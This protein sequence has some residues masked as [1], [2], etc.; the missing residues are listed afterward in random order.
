MKIAG[1]IKTKKEMQ[2][3]F[4][5]NERK[6]GLFAM[7]GGG[8][9]VFLALFSM[10]LYVVSIKLPQAFDFFAGVQ[11]LFDIIIPVLLVGELVLIFNSPGKRKFSSKWWFVAATIF[12]VLTVRCFSGLMGCFVDLA[13]FR[14]VSLISAFIDV[15][16]LAGYGILTATLFEKN[17][18]KFELVGFGII[19]FTKLLDIL[20]LIVQNE[21]IELVNLFPIVTIVLLAVISFGKENRILRNLVVIS[22][23]IVILFT[24]TNAYFLE[25][26]AYIILAFL[27]VPAGKLK[28][29]WYFI[30]AIAF[31]AMA[32][33]TLV[34]FGHTTA[35]TQ[36]LVLLAFIVAPLI[37]SVCF[38]IK[39]FNI[40]AIIGYALMFVCLVISTFYN[41]GIYAFDNFVDSLTITLIV[42][43][44]AL[45]LFG[46]IL[47]NRDSEK[48]SCRKI[49]LIVLSILVS[50]S[51][52]SLD[53]NRYTGYYLEDYKVFDMESILNILFAVAMFTSAL[54]LVPFKY[55]KY[56]G[57][58]KHIFLS[59]I[60]CGI[61]HYIWV[62]NVTKN[63]EI[64]DK[65][66]NCKYALELILYIFMPLYYIYWY[67]KAA[68]AT[69]KYAQANGIESKNAI[70]VFLLS[71]VSPLVSS[72]LIQNKFNAVETK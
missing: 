39:K 6:C 43:A 4:K 37:L 36:V 45:V 68:Y 22:A 38:F 30:P 3:M 11:Y 62:Y 51:I 19:G 71:F 21:P 23:I 8:L 67:Y 25:F 33:Y 9:I 52:F 64:V 10:L 24:G 61:W 56:Q 31:L 40:L 34:G 50:L 49:V 44:I 70:M 16:G 20:N 1:D 60:T 13:N 47:F 27:M 15:V 41:N 58:G 48:N 28:V 42:K 59:L 17:F 46:L 65:D 63:L 72:V 7:V 14:E 29:D 26:V 57:I 55:K 12:Y 32:V 66:R 69:D 2:K 18:K 5:G 53:I 54:V 35:F